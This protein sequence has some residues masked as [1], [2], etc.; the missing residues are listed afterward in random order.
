MNG[1]SIRCFLINVLF[2][3]YFGLWAVLYF[4]ATASDEVGAIHTLVGSGVMVTSFVGGWVSAFVLSIIMAFRMF[5]VEAFSRN[6]IG[7]HVL[8][9]L[10]Q[11]MLSAVVILVPLF[12]LKCVALSQVRSP[13][14]LA[15]VIVLFLIMLVATYRLLS[16]CNREVLD[17]E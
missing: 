2:C 4:L 5:S 10:T 11:L 1:Y 12:F 16:T 13:L 8:A 7:V 3:G 17:A 15:I 6:R 14:V 9:G